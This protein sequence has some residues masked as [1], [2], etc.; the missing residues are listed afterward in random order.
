MK[1]RTSRYNLMSADDACL[2]LIFRMRFPTAKGFYRV[3]G[4]TIY[5]HQKGYKHLSP[6]TETIFE[7]SSTPLSLWFQAIAC[8]VI[9]GKK[10]P[11]KELQRHLGVT[12]KT[13]WRMKD[14]ITKALIKETINI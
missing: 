9:T 13:A 8:V 5:I 7:K 1:K 6:L 4:K 10:I 3:R 11:A 2:D 14:L 12:Y